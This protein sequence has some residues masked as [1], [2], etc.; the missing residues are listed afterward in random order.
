MGYGTVCWHLKGVHL[1]WTLVGD[2]RLVDIFALDTLERLAV[3]LCLAWQSYG[4]GK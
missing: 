2:K 1:D 3:E 4:S